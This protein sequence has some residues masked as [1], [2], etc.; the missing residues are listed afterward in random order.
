MNNLFPCRLFSTGFH[1]CYYNMGLDEAL[2]E[3]CAAEKESLPVLRFYGW[4]PPAVSI[5]YF[6]R[7]SEE[8]DTEAVNRL[9]FDLVR[10]ISGGGAVLHSSELTYSIIIGQHHP[11]AGSGIGESYRMLCKGLIRGLEIL[12]IKAVFSGINDILAGEKKISGNAQT[13]RNGCLLQHGTILLDNDTETMFEVL[14]IS[15]E[16]I[17]GKLIS[18]A[19]ERVTS[20]RLILDRIIGFDEAEAVF[21]RGFGEA[22]GLE[23]RKSAVD[24]SLENRAKE[25]AITKFSSEEWLLKR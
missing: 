12:G 4:S 19:K 8:V 5:G 25:L 18:E 9:G 22:L 2:L 24:S 10:R 6:Q 3:S 17:K 23:F 21:T 14:K 15:D 16:K 1:D 20:L 13:R 11:L 7:L